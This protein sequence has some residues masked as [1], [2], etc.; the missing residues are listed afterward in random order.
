M[1]KVMIVGLDCAE[2]SLVLERWRDEL[3]VLSGLMDQGAY[4]RLTSVIPPITVPAWSCMMASRTPGDLGVYGFRNRADHSY[5]ALFIANSTAIREQ[6]LWD[7]V[8]RAGKPSIVLGVPGTYPPRPLNGVMVSCFLTPS[9]ESQYTFPPMLKREIEQTVG[10][11]VLDVRDFRTDDKDYLLRQVYE[12]TDRRFA[13]AEHLLATKPWEL[14]AMVEMGPDRM[15]H[16][17]WKMM[18]PEHRGHEPGNRFES[19]IL[20]YHKHL[21]ELMGRLLARAGED[22]AV[23]V[24]SDHGGKRMDGGIR[25]NEWL[26]R[27]G[28]LATLREPQGVERLHDVGIDWSRTTAWGE[29]G[30]Y[31]RIFLNVAGREPEGTIPP[32]DVERVRADLA[33]RLA[34]IPDE[35]G[36]PLDTKVYVPEEV[37]DQVN[38]VAPDLIVHFGDLLWRS[39][40]TVGGDEGIHT[41][42]NDTGPDDA[43]HA[44]EGM[45]VLVAP[46]VPP[47]PRQGARL[48]DVAPTV[49]ELMGLAVPAAMRGTSLLAPSA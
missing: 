3:P 15:Y 36:A 16:G 37:Y 26:R 23:F 44:Q 1:S 18:D 19:A 34:A 5:D 2:P 45:F 27:E 42:E 20:D 33:E 48:L 9:T 14:F 30:Y 25:V 49:L 46:G 6:R 35:N 24:V 39:V 7:L 31:S 12:M 13:L 38:G 41:F 32:E 11:Y 43:N 28:L 29:G 40:G 21:D 10:E 22:T 47:G 17:F 4:G 8:T